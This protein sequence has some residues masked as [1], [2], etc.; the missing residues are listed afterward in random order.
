MRTAHCA[1]RMND[2]GVE[3]WSK[4]RRNFDPPVSKF[5]RNFDQTPTPPVSKFGRSLLGVSMKCIVNLIKCLPNCGTKL[6]PNFDQTST[7]GVSKFGR[8]F[9]QTSTL[10]GRS[11]VGVSTKLRHH[12]VQ[13]KL[14]YLKNKLYLQKR[15]TVFNNPSNK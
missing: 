9:D 14:F 13:R 1:L 5:G 11:L 6:R 10:G 15:V 7:L 2:V 3:V 8:N 4:F 12:I